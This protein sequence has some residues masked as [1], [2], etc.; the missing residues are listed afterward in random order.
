MVVLVVLVPVL[1]RLGL[2]VLF[3]VPYPGPGH[4]RCGTE[5]AE[6][7]I[8]AR[9]ACVSLSRTLPCAVLN[10]RVERG[11]PGGRAESL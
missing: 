4:P 1:A 3:R 9:A 8:F 5:T 10:F 7:C 11:V 2:V 6:F